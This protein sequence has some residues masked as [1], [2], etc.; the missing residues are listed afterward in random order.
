MSAFIRKCSRQVKMQSCTLMMKKRL[1]FL[2]SIFKSCQ[3]TSTSKIHNFF[4]FL[5]FK[6]CSVCVDVIATNDSTISHMLIHGRSCV[7]TNLGSTTAETSHLNI[8]TTCEIKEVCYHEC[9]S[10]VVV[11]YLLFVLCFWLGFKLGIFLMFFLDTL[12]KLFSSRV[13]S[14][15]ADQSPLLSGVASK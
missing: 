6:Q 11:C 12:E 1:N 10:F 4:S 13:Y 5:L 14:E 7:V 9:C 3:C 2:Y 8:K 15:V